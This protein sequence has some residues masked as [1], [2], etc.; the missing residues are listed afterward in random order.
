MKIAIAIL[1]ASL[2]LSACSNKLEKQREMNFT[3]TETATTYFL[4]A[5]DL[6]RQDGFTIN[7]ISEKDGTLSAE[8]DFI[9]NKDT[10]MI[11]MDININEKRDVR[12]RTTAH[13]NSWKDCKTRE[14]YDLETYNKDYETKFYSTL[15]SLKEFC[16]GPKFPNR[17]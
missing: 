11:F 3:C 2:A 15:R 14:Y 9:E 10:V 13:I 17:P 12:I 6:L 7:S 8:K 4:N 1:A 5:K 16:S